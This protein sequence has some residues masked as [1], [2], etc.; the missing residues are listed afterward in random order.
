MGR[1]IEADVDILTA[2]LRYQFSPDTRITNLTRVGQTDN[3]YLTT[4]ARASLFG[5]N[6]PRAGA[7]TISLSTHQGWQEVEYFVNQTNLNLRPFKGCWMVNRKPERLP[8][9]YVHYWGLTSS[10]ALTINK[11][12]ANAVL[13]I[14]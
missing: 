8:D 11:R 10:Y 12:N 9:R 7:P 3:G 1:D 13:S 2:R 6:D 4:G 5:V 14:S